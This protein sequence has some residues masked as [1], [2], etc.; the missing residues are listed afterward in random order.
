VKPDDAADKIGSVFVP[1]QSA[2]KA[3]VRRR[4]GPLVAVGANA[5]RSGAIA[6]LKPKPGDRVLYAQY[7]GSEVKK[8]ADGERYCVMND[9]D[10]LAV[11]EAEQ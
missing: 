5:F 3:E 6:A 4:E 8:G 10:L 1:E 11:L 7:A 2:D 9:A